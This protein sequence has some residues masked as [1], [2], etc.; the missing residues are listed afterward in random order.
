MGR[1]LLKA[2]TSMIEKEVVTGKQAERIKE[3]EESV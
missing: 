3:L 2:E 1:K